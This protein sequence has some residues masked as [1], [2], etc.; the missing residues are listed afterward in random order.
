[1]AKR[2]K[3]PPAKVAPVKAQINSRQDALRARLRGEW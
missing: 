2:K 1:M 3:Q